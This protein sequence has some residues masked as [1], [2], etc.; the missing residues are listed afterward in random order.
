MLTT[1]RRVFFAPDF[2]ACD[3]SGSLSF[4][5]DC[6]LNVVVTIKKNQQHDEHIPSATMMMAGCCGVYDEETHVKKSVES[7]ESRVWLAES[8][9]RPSSLVSP[10]FWL[11]V[12]ASFLFRVLPPDEVVAERLHFGRRVLDFF[13]VITPRDERGDGDGQA[14][15]V[16]RKINAMPWASLAASFRPVWPRFANTVIM[17]ADGADQP[18]NGAMRRMISS[19]TG[20]VRAGRLSWRAASFAAA[21]TL[22]PRPVEMVGGEQQQR[23][24]GDGFCAHTRRSAF[25]SSRDLQAASVSQFVPA[26]PCPS[27]TQWRVPR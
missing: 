4:K 19:T 24:S 8:G 11:S 5:A 21:S 20:R 1:K 16:A 26:Q 17:P 25:T 23:P 22:S 2:W 6:C 13:A 3:D 27:A 10:T 15:N 14:I 9:L 18:S 7:R 12:V